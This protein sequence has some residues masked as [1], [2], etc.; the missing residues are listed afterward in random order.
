ME[1]SGTEYWRPFPSPGD[2]PN[3]GIEPRSPT[4]QVDSLSAELSGKLN[5]PSP[6]KLYVI[7]SLQGD[8]T[9]PF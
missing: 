1:F 9:S 2:L 3:L 4:L 6:T 8:P 5:S 7:I